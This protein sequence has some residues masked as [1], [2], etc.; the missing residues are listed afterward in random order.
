MLGHRSVADGV[1]GIDE[2][3]QNAFLEEVAFWT[4]I[5]AS[6]RARASRLCQE[7]SC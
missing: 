5:N 2:V 4:A 6:Y 3:F 1:V 7:G